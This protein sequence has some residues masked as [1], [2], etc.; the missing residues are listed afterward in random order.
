M[1][2]V[3]AAGGSLTPFGISGTLSSLN[4]SFR[5]SYLDYCPELKMIYPV[6]HSSDCFGMSAQPIKCFQFLCQDAMQCKESRETNWIQTFRNGQK[7]QIGIKINAS[8]FP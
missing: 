4:T 8:I 3:T 7:Y 5:T 1:F 2:G 6:L